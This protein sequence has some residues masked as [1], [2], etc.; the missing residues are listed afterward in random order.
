MNNN[1]YYNLYDCITKNKHRYCCYLYKR[2]QS[3][4]EVDFYSKRPEK[5]KYILLKINSKQ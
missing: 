4:D 1:I 5:S 3:V 2:K